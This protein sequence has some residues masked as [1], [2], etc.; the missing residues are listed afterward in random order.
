[1]VICDTFIE[2]VR[3]GKLQ[4]GM[5]HLVRQHPNHRFKDVREAAIKWEKWKL[6]A[7]SRVWAYSCE[8]QISKGVERNVDMHA[9]TVGASEELKEFKEFFHKQQAQLDTILKHLSVPSTAAAS[10]TTPPIPRLTAIIIDQS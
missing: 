6:Q 5:S 9:I 1:M 10:H 4:R 3:D 7:N 2:N 8:S